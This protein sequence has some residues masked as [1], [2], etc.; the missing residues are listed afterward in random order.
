MPD[1]EVT[2]AEPSVDAGAS[3]DLA[4]STVDTGEVGQPAAGESTDVV[5]AETAGTFRALDA[6]GRMLP[7]TAA[8]V[9]TLS[10]QLAGYVSRALA[11]AHTL[12]A[13]FRGKSPWAEINRLEKLD[14]RLKGESG[15]E[16]I[17]AELSDVQENDDL[18]ARSDPKLL[19]KMTETPAAR[20]AFV[21]LL[22]H[23]MFKWQSI[24][25][26][27]YSQYMGRFMADNMR[28]TAIAEDGTPIDLAVRLR[29]IVSLTFPVDKEG[30]PRTATQIENEMLGEDLKAVQKYV[31]IVQ[32]LTKLQ[33]EELAP[34]RTDPND[35]ELELSRRERQLVQEQWKSALNS[36]LSRPYTEEWNKQTAGREMTAEQGERIRSLFKT[37]L[38]IVQ[39]MVPDYAAT[40]AELENSGDRAGF[41]Q[42]HLEFF[43]KNAP[44]I[45]AREIDAVLG[46]RK[47]GAAPATGSPARPAASQPTQQ[48]V[49]GAVRL[50]TAPAASELERGSR[51]AAMYR[52]NRGILNA[53][54]T[55]G[56]PAGTE[57]YW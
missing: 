11:T 1:T 43:R 19:D 27:S 26:L 32:G 5:T 57:V 31:S 47:K 14:K 34:E 48:P 9:K 25:P 42:L 10:P 33:P 51:A 55:R 21:K 8:A 30:N 56:L 6:R 23:A 45:L 17:A 44:G 15:L 38:R 2:V 7:E 4:I 28:N 36:A 52:E 53:K 18:F 24:A 12:H 40:V 54:N 20:A 13:R 49:T 39:K 16:A 37:R 46:P 50:R 35:R 3:T 41:I 22:P 29:R